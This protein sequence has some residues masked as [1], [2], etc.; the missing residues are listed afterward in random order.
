[1]HLKLFR[2]RHPHAGSSIPTP[3]ANVCKSLLLIRTSHTR[4][5]KLIVNRMTRL[6]VTMSA[7]FYWEGWE[8]R[9]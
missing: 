2:N 7:V 3:G 5:Q 1:M 8:V 6:I 4:P 9:A